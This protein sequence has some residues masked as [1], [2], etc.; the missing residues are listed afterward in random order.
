[1]LRIVLY[2]TLGFLVSGMVGLIAGAIFA[3]GPE[4]KADPLVA[5]AI[6]FIGTS[7]SIAL[8]SWMNSVG[9]AKLESFSERPGIIYGIFASTLG[10]YAV[11]IAI[12]AFDPDNRFPL[13]A[14]AVIGGGIIIFAYA[15]ATLARSFNMP[16]NL[17]I[18]V[19]LTA[20]LILA[21]LIMAESLMN[22][23]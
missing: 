15:G 2:G 6:T 3:G 10:G 8:A 18:G 5:A 4:A 7:L 12:R 9:N 21:S 1:M 11:F 19:A 20:G 17:S 14:L 13:L 22:R 23:T 16:K